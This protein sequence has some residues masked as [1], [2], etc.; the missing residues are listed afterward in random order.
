MKLP[1]LPNY[2]RFLLSHYLLGVMLFSV[3]RLILFVLR[4]LPWQ[5][6]RENW[7]LV[8]TAFANGLR[9]DTVVMGY[10]LLL[11]ALV[12]TAFSFSQRSAPHRALLVFLRTCMLPAF[13]ICSIDIPYTRYHAARLSA[14][15]FNWFSDAGT[16]LQM[17]REEQS[18]LWF[19]LLFVLTWLVYLWDSRRIQGLAKRTEMAMSL[20]N[21]VLYALLTLGLVFM[22][23][24]GRVDSPIKTSHAFFSNNP[25]YNQ[26]GLNPVFTLMKSLSER[27]RA[28]LMDGDLA[29][30]QMQ[31]YLHLAPEEVRPTPLARCLPV[32]DT[33]KPLNVVLVL[34]ESMSA[35]KLGHFGNT[36]GLTPFLDSLASQSLCFDRMY[37]AGRHT[38][39]GIFST[40]YGFPAILAEH[41]MSATEELIPYAGLPLTL[42]DAGYE[43]FFFTTHDEGFDN[44]GAFLRAHGMKH[45]LSQNNYP[46]EKITMKAFGV[47]DHVMFRYAADTLDRFSQ[48]TKPFFA[49]LM[50][51]SDHPPYVLPT[52]IPFHP[53]QP[54]LHEQIVA[55]A[56]WALRDFMQRC[57]EKSW[58]R[59][60]VFV[61]VADHGAVVGEQAHEIPLSYHH[62]P[63]MMFCA[64]QDLLTARH[65]PQPS[66]QMDIGPALLHLLNRPYWNT[67]PGINP[68]LESRPYAFFS[69][70][71]RIG[72]IDSNFYYVYNLNGAEYLY[73]LSDPG[74][75]NCATQYPDTLQQMKRYAF[76]MIRGS[77]KL[78][79]EGKTTMQKKLP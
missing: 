36:Q 27:H 69:S 55:Y 22:A 15:I 43:T 33:P 61:F 77:K 56:D 8:R 31:T 21:R 65:I 71:D 46:P 59:N 78:M 14:V 64:E 48:S 53:A 37:S 76:A 57:A 1:P 24:R 67:T 7:I 25:F 39:N 10:I 13:F 60:T 9:F 45:I 44:L 62:I 72:C 34:M 51:V 75:Q 26:L 23:I 50:T 68:F 49:T 5:H 63:C 41:P 4:D 32:A 74:A 47:P 70:D 16:M 58:F 52:D 73:R 54:D 42:Q 2:L 20:T 11:P 38:Y 40:L 18:Y 17:V 28:N 29:L 19:G 6:I 35:N 3:F 79:E 12:L 66:C 30:Q